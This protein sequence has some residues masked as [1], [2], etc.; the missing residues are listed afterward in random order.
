MKK[1]RGS[2]LEAPP[3]KRHK[4]CTNLPPRLFIGLA[5]TWN[6]IYVPGKVLENPVAIGWSFADDEETF[7]PYM[8]SIEPL[9]NSRQ[10]IEIHVLQDWEELLN[11]SDRKLLRQGRKTRLNAIAEFFPA[12]LATLIQD[13]APFE[14]SLGRQFWV[15]WHQPPPRSALSRP[16]LSYQRTYITALGFKKPTHYSDC[17]D[18]KECLLERQ[19]MPLDPEGPDSDTDSDEDVIGINGSMCSCPLNV[20]CMGDAWID[21]PLY[22]RGVA[23]TR[24]EYFWHPV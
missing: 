11:A 19:V 23:W 1:R 2:S 6:E 21:L 24:A 9:N 17:N 10:V 22:Q 7:Q 4:S 5:T 18:D 13:Y 8:N 3:E 15:R 12:T 20:C 14:E 16:V